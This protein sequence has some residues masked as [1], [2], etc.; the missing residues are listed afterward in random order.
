MLPS[1]AAG[2]LKSQ[3]YPFT[4]NNNADCVYKLRTSIGSIL[5][6]NFIA[7]NLEGHS[8]SCSFDWLQIFD[9]PGTQYAPL[10]PKL[11]GTSL[12]DPGSV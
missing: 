3:N 6:F 7:F 9:G 11:C 1:G 8:S 2:E 10:T 12:P 5:D 4:Y